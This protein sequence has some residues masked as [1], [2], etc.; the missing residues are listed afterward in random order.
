MELATFIQVL[1]YITVAAFSVY[2]VG[3]SPLCTFSIF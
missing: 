3:T 1:H 2:V